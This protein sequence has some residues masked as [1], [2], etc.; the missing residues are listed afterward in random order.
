M[1]DIFIL[2]D[3]KIYQRMLE[4]QIPEGLTHVLAKDGKEFDEYLAGDGRAR[5]YFLD[6]RVPSASGRMQF[7]FITH[8]SKLL[9]KQPGAKVFYTGSTPWVNEKEYCK[10]NKIPMV[11]RGSIADIIKSE[12]ETK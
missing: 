11:D 4:S 5:L 2:E 12:L 3:D 9:E 1:E 7:L 8:C 6:D 10:E